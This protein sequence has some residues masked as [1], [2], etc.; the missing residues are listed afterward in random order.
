MKLGI[1][2]SEHNGIIDFEKVKSQIDFVFIRAT[3]GKKNVDKCFER[4]IKECIRLN[5]PFGVYVYSYALNLSDAIAES[6]FL[7]N[8]IEPYKYYISLPIAIDMEDADGYKKKN[9][10]PT[11]EMLCNICKCECDMFENRGYESMIYASASWFNTILN[12]RILDGYKKW[13]AWWNDK[14]QVNKEKYLFHQFSSTGKVNGING[15]VDMN[16]YFN[17]EV[18]NE[19]EILKKDLKNY[20]EY[21]RKTFEKLIDS[22]FLKG[23]DGKLELS[24]SMIRTF[25]ILDRMGILKF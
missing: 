8:K 15:N 13:I 24:D 9:G 18:L 22:G 19:K 12:S 7:L 25:V 23:I 21:A 4:N 17:S 10:M 2:I 20:P 6:T 5:I 14:A 3:F 16:Y 11:N 1:D